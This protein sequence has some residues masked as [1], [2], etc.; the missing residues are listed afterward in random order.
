VPAGE[1]FYVLTCL[2]GDHGATTEDVYVVVREMTGGEIRG[3]IDSD[4]LLVK[5]YRKGQL[6]AFPEA[7]LVD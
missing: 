7:R 5:A 2:Y 4:V 1:K 3:V 6:L